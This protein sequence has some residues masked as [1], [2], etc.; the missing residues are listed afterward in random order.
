MARYII[1]LMMVVVASVSFTLF[2]LWNSVWIVGSV[3]LF[4]L[5]IALIFSK[6]YEIDDELERI[7]EY[8]WNN[9]K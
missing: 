3:F 8:L 4:A 9:R 7:K 2:F 6:I 5:G 1:G